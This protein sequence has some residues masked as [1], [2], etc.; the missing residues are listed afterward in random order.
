VFVDNP[1][2]VESKLN[3]LIHHSSVNIN[4]EFL[5]IIKAYKNEINVSID[6]GNKKDI[7]IET[8][9]LMVYNNGILTPVYDK[10][11]NNYRRVPFGS[12]ISENN[13]SNLKNGDYFLVQYIND[14]NN[15]VKIPFI[16][17]EPLNITT[18]D[19]GIQSCDV[20]VDINYDYNS[21]YVEI[22]YIMGATL[23]NNNIKKDSGICYKE[24]LKLITGIMKTFMDGY[25]CDIFYE[26]IDFNTNLKS[27]YKEK[28]NRSVNVNMTN[29]IGM[30]CDNFSITRNG[31]KPLLFTRENDNL[32]SFPK[33]DFNIVFNRG[34]AAGWEKHF[35]L[36][37]CNTMQDLINYGNNFFNL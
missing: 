21:K 14:E 6:F 35:K 5:G 16:L 30:N 20:V 9:Q 13:F 25:E 2:E 8:G 33:T 17:N 23:E 18:Y 28:L 11:I 34:N 29:I 15:P 31:N 37:E 12:C 10:N 32:S 36:S 27:I 4:E 1:I 26:K 19:N 22:T 24:K 3:M 7:I